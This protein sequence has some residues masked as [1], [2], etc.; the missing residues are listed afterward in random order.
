MIITYYVDFEKGSWAVFCGA[1]ISRNS[2]IPIA[3]DLVRATLESFGIGKQHIQ[4]ILSLNLPFE[5][6]MG[7]LRDSVGIDDLLDMFR[8]A[9]P[10]ANHFLLAQLAKERRIT[11]LVTTNFDMLIEDV[12]RLLGLEEGKDFLIYCNERDFQGLDFGNL[13]NGP[14]RIFKIHGSISD[15][16]TIRVTL[17]YVA[18]K[19]LSLQ[20][21]NILRY[22]FANEITHTG[23][24][25]KV[26][27]LGY[28]CSDSFDI[29]PALEEFAPYSK[30][31]LVIDHA[32]SGKLY[33]EDL[34]KKSDRNPFRAYRGLRLKVNISILNCFL[35]S[36]SASLANSQSVSHSHWREVVDQWYARIEMT[37]GLRDYVIGELYRVGS[38]YDQAL[39]AYTSAHEYY[40]RSNGNLMH[41]RTA[42]RMGACY[43]YKLE[44]RNSIASYEEALMIARSLTDKKLERVCCSALML[45]HMETGDIEKADEYNKLVFELTEDSDQPD[46]DHVFSIGLAYSKGENTDAAL[47][48]ME[49]ALDRA[50]QMG[51]IDAQ[52]RCHSNIAKFY[53]NARLN[54]DAVRHYLAAE[55]LCRKTNKPTLLMTIYFNLATYYHR[56]EQLREALDYYARTLKLSRQLA[57]KSSSA[58]CYFRIAVVLILLGD[59]GGAFIFLAHAG[60]LY[61]ELKD[62]AMEEKCAEGCRIIARAKELSDQ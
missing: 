25:K 24:H 55:E 31:V 57:D 60:V 56:I 8:V 23:N 48:L 61:Q 12:C 40:R 38:L 9:T 44:Y 26:L 50:E 39:M 36:E 19:V 43:A 52:I 22:L 33:V 30:E 59:N 7:I 13:S 10:N 6:V 45:G 14:M 2:G 3:A 4:T 20:R 34:K 21:K 41:A 16:Q 32:S 42:I 27:V 5:V 15:P 29:S 35:S 11:T 62:K 37:N 51:D 18:S 53:A 46:I 54:E 47:S 1:G 17:D 49:W 58:A 28:S